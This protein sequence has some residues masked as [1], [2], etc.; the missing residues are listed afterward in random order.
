VATASPV[1]PWALVATTKHIDHEEL[2]RWLDAKRPFA[3]VDVLPAE[4]FREGHLPGSVNACVYEVTFLDQVRALVP[5]QRMPV[6]AYC[7][8]ESSLASEDA[9]ER[10]AGAG[11]EEVYRFAGGRDAWRDAGYPFEGR[12]DEPAEE[13]PPDGKHAIDLKRSVIGWVGRNPGGSHDGTLRLRSG[14]ITVK[15]GAI[16]KGVFEVDMASLEIG[17]LEGDM[18]D[19]LKR[20][21]ESDDFFAV[22]S[23]PVARFETTRMIPVEGATPGAPNYEVEGELTARGV[24]NPVAFPATAALRSGEL[25]LEAHFDLDRTRW[26]ANYGSGKLYA[27]LGMHL[28]HDHITLQTRVVAQV[29]G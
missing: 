11:Y 9:A 6:V 25:T 8:G 3:L 29:N 4:V 12:A 14:Q 23:H 10:L 27:R 1:R 24:T 22:E 19:L 20:H 16:A 21:L 15:N 7:A 2:K 28:V 13:H 18:A 26:N 5:D 17:D